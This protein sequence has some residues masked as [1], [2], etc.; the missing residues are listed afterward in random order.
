MTDKL[1]KIE[2]TIEFTYEQ[3]TK[4][5]HPFFRYIINKVL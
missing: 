5:N 1:N 3:E 4:K 2:P